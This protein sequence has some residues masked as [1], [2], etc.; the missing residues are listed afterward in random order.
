MKEF[1]I[2]QTSREALTRER[3]EDVLRGLGEGNTAVK[4]SG[5]SFGDGSAEV[6]ASALEKTV[7]SL[8]FLDMADIIASRPEDEAK[9]TLT[10]IAT[11]LACCKHLE[12]INLSDN[13][14]GAK[15]INAVG[16]LLK[17]QTKLKELYLCNN[18][19]AADA[20]TLICSALLATVPSSLTTLHFHNNLL[21]TAGSLALAPII[22]SSPRLE[23]FRFSSLRVGREGTV[24]ICEALQPQLSSTLKHLNLADNFFGEEG[25]DSLARALLN[26]PLLETLIINDTIIGDSGA[27]SICKVLMTG[28]PNL[29]VLNI[30]GNEIGLQGA[31]GIAKLLSSGRL[32]ELHADDNELGNAGA[33]ALA[34]G[35]SRHSHLRVLGLNNCEIGGPGALSIAKAISSL[36]DVKCVNLDSNTISTSQLEKIKCL[37]GT[38]LGPMDEN[39]EDGEFESDLEEEKSSA[40]EETEEETKRFPNPVDQRLSDQRVDVG[41]LVRVFKDARIT[42]P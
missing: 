32:R 11:A 5:K 30:S 9:R 29:S 3:A 36:K 28:A 37:L 41:D 42:D 35:I 15:G 2:D 24:R 17:G 14:L 18:G 4:L 19:L 31:N 25:A 16:D 7:P 10:T 27:S 20:G 1:L 8:R 33:T 21:E 12:S 38:K 23:D 26:A 40:S 34:E 13:A 6:L 22:E 39:D